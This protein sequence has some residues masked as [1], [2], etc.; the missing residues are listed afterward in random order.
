[1]TTKTQTKTRRNTNVDAYE[2]E[3]VS[4]NSRSFFKAWDSVFEEDWAK[5][6]P[7]ALF[8]YLNLAHMANRK[9]KSWNVTNPPIWIAEGDLITSYERL[10]TKLK[11]TIKVMRGLVDYL[12]YNDLVEKVKHKG[13]T[14]GIIKFIHLRLSRWAFEQVSQKSQGHYK[15]QQLKN[16]EEQVATSE[17]V[18][19]REDLLANLRSRFGSNYGE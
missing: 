4:K 15:G 1:M 12:I 11:V 16:I 19:S 5:M 17:E 9:A 14:K 6:K 18:G 2:K 10:A 3:I 7:M 8:L 13:T